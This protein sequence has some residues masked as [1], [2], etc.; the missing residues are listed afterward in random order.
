MRT[1][2]RSIGSP[3]SPP[4]VSRTTSSRGALRR[5]RRMSAASVGVAG[6]GPRWPAV[7][8]SPRDTPPVLLIGR[9]A[10]SCGTGVTRSAVCR[11]WVSA[12]CWDGVTPCRWCC[13]GRRTGAGTAWCTPMNSVQRWRASRMWTRRSGGHHAL[14]GGAERGARPGEAL[15]PRAGGGAHQEAR[16]DPDGREPGAQPRG[17]AGERHPRRGWAVRRPAG[18]RGARAVRPCSSN[19]TP[20]TLGARSAGLESGA[21]GRA[22]HADGHH[23]VRQASARPYWPG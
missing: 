21:A 15:R 9:R 12:S 3:P 4:P 5:G 11:R 13:R 7:R 10:Y 6:Y 22:R 8:A 20:G 16:G 18:L 17:P 14:R 1:L 23:A 2:K 19:W